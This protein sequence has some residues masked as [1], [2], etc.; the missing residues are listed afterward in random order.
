[1]LAFS[2]L[3]FPSA[4]LI[5]GEDNIAKFHPQGFVQT[6]EQTTNNEFLQA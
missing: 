6:D 1:M 5:T 2:N 4:Y 3:T